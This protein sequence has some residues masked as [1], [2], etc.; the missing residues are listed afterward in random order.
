M[1]TQ[2]ASLQTEL[3]GFLREEQQAAEKKASQAKAMPMNC[4]RS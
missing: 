2:V 3:M 1:I 4:L